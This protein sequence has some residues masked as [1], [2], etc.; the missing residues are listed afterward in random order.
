MKGVIF[1]ELIRFMES[2]KSPAF[3]DEAIQLSAVASD[4]A[5]TTVGNYPSGEALALVGAASKLSGTDAAELCRLF[6][7]YLFQRFLILYPHIMM[8]Y[9]NAETLLEH[10]GSHIHGEVCVLYPD[11][12]PPQIEA[13]TVDNV[14]T[15]SYK[16]HRPMAAIAFGLIEECMR[17]YG[18]E[19][20]VSWNSSENGKSATFVIG[21]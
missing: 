2:V 18:D 6:G 19:R 13:E 10:V 8:S 17:H 20:S 9:T 7:G 11:A 14:T 15:M 5:Y 1:T 4:G 12:R 21:A 16:S 3:A